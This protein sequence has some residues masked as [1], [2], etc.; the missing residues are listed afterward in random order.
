MSR[1]SEASVP[2]MLPLYQRWANEGVVK[3][4]LLLQLM[5][6]RKKNKRKIWKQ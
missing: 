1:G 4:K 5:V 6:M 2:Q 3:V